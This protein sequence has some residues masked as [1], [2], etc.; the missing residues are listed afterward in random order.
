M[1]FSNCYGHGKCNF[2]SRK[3]D[4]N[5]G[6]LEPN[7]RFEV[8]T[9]TVATTSTTS[10]TTETTTFTAVSQTDALKSSTDFVTTSTTTAEDEAQ[11]FMQHQPIKNNHLI[12]ESDA[13]ITKKPIDSSETCESC[14]RN[15]YNNFNDNENGVENEF[16][17]VAVILIVVL[18]VMIAMMLT[19]VI[20]LLAKGA[21]N[22][23]IRKTADK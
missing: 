20:S 21:V 12:F 10:T 22:V 11:F 6:Y 9:T 17:N 19:V 8:P 3:C 13:E 16:T 5:P 7:C 15:I 1:R 14:A 4:C 2:T 23:H 18:L